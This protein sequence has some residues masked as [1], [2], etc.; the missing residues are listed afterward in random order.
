MRALVQR[1]RRGCV[2]VDGETLAEI[3][4]GMVILLGVGDRDSEQ[5]ARWLAGKCANLRIFED[6]G[7]KMNRSLLDSG[8]KALVVSQFTLYGDVS[9]GRRPSFVH[10]ADPEIAEPL[11]EKFA[12][13]LRGE[14]VTTQTGSFGANM[15]VEIE[16][17][18]P[19]TL[20]IERD[21]L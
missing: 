14:G 16:N 3:G 7:G 6:D 9:K 11:V 1:V 5:E 10:A 4:P 21:S 2:S 20:M 8:G 15:L 17:D 19:V 13:H 18:G 12:E